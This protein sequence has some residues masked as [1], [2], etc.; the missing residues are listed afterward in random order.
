MEPPN[1]PPSPTLP[2]ADPDVVTLQV[3]RE[4]FERLNA[5]LAADTDD[6]VE[7]PKKLVDL[8]TQAKTDAVPVPRLVLA[9]LLELLSAV[10]IYLIGQLE[11]CKVEPDGGTTP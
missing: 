8:L 7:V 1:L 9:Q 11:R 2:K 4:Q 3:P 5:L 10:R 6:T